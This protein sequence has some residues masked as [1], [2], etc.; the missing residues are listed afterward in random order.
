[1]RS[2]SLTRL[3]AR[4]ILLACL[5]GCPAGCRDST[6]L[7]PLAPAVPVSA[8]SGL[9]EGTAN[10]ES[11]LVHA[12]A[13]RHHVDANRVSIT[14]SFRL[15]VSYGH[16]EPDVAP[17]LVEYGPW[18]QDHDPHPGDWAVPGLE[19]SAT[20]LVRGDG[21]ALPIEVG[22]P[23]RVLP[24][25]RRAWARVLHPGI[26]PDVCVSPL[27]TGSE[28]DAAMELEIR[29]RPG[30]LL[31]GTVLDSMGG[32][33]SGAEVHLRSPN[34]R[35]FPV[36]LSS[37]IT[38]R[39]GRFLLV[40]RRTG[41]YDVIARAAGSGSAILPSMS[42][43]V[44]D[45]D[46]DLIVRLRGSAVIRGIVRDQHDRPVVGAPL[47][48]FEIDAEQQKD[49]AERGMPVGSATSDA[50]GRFTIGGLRTGLYHVMADAPMTLITQDGFGAE[51]VDTR[52]RRDVVLRLDARR[53]WVHCVDASGVAIPWRP[54][55][56]LQSMNADLQQDLQQDVLETRTSGLGDASGAGHDWRP[57]HDPSIWALWIGANGRHRVTL[58]SATRGWQ[59]ADVSIDLSLDP[60]QL[61]FELPDAKTPA[62]LKVLVDPMPAEFHNGYLVR[63]EPLDGIAPVQ[64]FRIDPKVASFEHAFGPAAYT[65][66]VIPMGIGA[67]PAEIDP[68]VAEH[69]LTA[70]ATTTIDARLPDAPEKDQ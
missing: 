41:T 32:P 11:G 14:D 56:T 6:E 13:E 9:P 5:V 7:E 43:S 35:S 50:M 46:T 68:L 33:V 25:S 20:I 49:H 3:G 24:R 64:R 69:V 55:S 61:T 44:E 15:I 58:G 37:A 27:R 2:P 66:C 29:T 22:F 53:V 19:V 47:L 40:A 36:D 62:R 1:M 38:D 28:S 10:L 59:Q 48:A 67:T 52:L 60:V 16:A 45:P 17:V 12:R 8:E 42:V 21:L 63:V 70:G 31:G 65:I 18:T 4:W 51:V 26:L 23:G 39:Q 30:G 54:A 34:A 57:T